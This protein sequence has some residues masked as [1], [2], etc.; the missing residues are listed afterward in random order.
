MRANGLRSR[1]MA[2]G[3]AWTL[4]GS[5]KTRSQKTACVGVAESPAPIAR[6]VRRFRWIHM[7][8]SLDRSYEDKEQRRAA[9]QQLSHKYWA[10]RTLLQSE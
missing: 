8:P 9:T 1:S 4:L 10:Q 6:C 3:Q 7:Q 5:R 2:L